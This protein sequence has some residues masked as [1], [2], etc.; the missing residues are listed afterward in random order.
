MADRDAL[1]NALAGGYYSASDPRWVRPEDL[2]NKLAP[3]QA[4]PTLPPMPD[5]RPSLSPHDPQAGRPNAA[6]APVS[7][8]LSPTMGAYGLAG[9]ATTAGLDARLGKYDPDT[10]TPLLAVAAMGAKRSPLAMDEASRMARAKEMGFGPETYY[11]GRETPYPGRRDYQMVTDNPRAASM[12]A[13]SSLARK[14]VDGGHVIPMRVNRNG[15]ADLTNNE[16]REAIAAQMARVLT[17]ARPKHY[18]PVTTSDALRMLDDG[19]T[20]GRAQWQNDT[21]IN[22]AK[23]AGFKGIPVHENWAQWGWPDAHSLAVFDRSHLRS[24][25]AA[26]D[27]AERNSPNL[28]AGLAGAA[29]LPGIAL[30]D[31]S[32]R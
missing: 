28:L 21:I 15:F 31:G 10:L 3:A 12:F 20:N 9:L 26:F 11:Q 16:H 25:I 19:I 23:A 8:M 7:D 13:D 27:P 4:W 6:T 32:D 29:V 22:A 1:I 24:P 14:G 2:R 18:A 5:N 30:S 17:E